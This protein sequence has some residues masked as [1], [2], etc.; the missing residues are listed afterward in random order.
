M[1]GQ[2]LARA[3]GI[4]RDRVYKWCTRGWLKPN[5]VASGGW[6]GEELWFNSEEH[7]VAQLMVALVRAGMYP[8]AAAKVARGNVGVVDRLLVALRTS[9]TV[10]ELR[11]QLHRDGQRLHGR[12]TASLGDLGAAGE[13]EPCL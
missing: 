8:D 2:E 4:P 11:Y 6:T 3:L 5:R 1:N 12:G 7:R 13:A 10:V 9:P